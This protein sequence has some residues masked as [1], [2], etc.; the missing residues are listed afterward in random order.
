VA[1]PAH[2][3]CVLVDYCFR[4]EMP[5][6]DSASRQEATLMDSSIVITALG[7]IVG[8]VISGGIQ[9]STRARRRLGLDRSLVL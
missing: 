4:G 6:F 2:C 9:A 3:A 5:I 8:T 1:R 7:A